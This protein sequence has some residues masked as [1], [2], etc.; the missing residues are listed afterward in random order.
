MVHFANAKYAHKII[1]GESHLFLLL[2]HHKLEQNNFFNSYNEFLS[3]NSNNKYSF[4]SHFDDSFKIQNKFMLLLEY[5]ETSCH[6]FFEQNQNPLNAAP[7][8]DVGVIVYNNSCPYNVEFTGLT[9]YSE[10]T[11]YLDGT[12]KPG[13]SHWW[14]Y[15]IGQ[16]DLWNNELQI[17]AYVE[18]KTPKIMELNLWVK[19]IDKLT[20]FHAELGVKMLFKNLL[21]HLIILN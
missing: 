11:T 18:E 14:Y 6:V 7:N 12:N 5:P 15:A 21:V 10:Q 1:H 13:L 9:K 20:Y 3:T 16:R 19:I 4:L 17:P 2:L 8:S